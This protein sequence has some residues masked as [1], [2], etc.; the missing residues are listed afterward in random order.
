MC[1]C[2]CVCVF[3]YIY[4]STLGVSRITWHV[5]VPMNL[6]SLSAINCCLSTP[7][8]P[9]SPT[10]PFPHATLFVALH[11]HPHNSLH[12]TSSPH[13]YLTSHHPRLQS[14]SS[15]SLQKNWFCYSHIHDAQGLLYI[16]IHI[17]CRRIKLLY[18]CNSEVHCKPE[19]PRHS[20]N[21]LSK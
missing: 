2:V 3:A 18:M 4:E 14:T 6:C 16:H 10:L 13:N 21:K 9:P 20:A 8:F 1:M 15:L 12:I 5:L 7:T 19:S 11:S 17:T